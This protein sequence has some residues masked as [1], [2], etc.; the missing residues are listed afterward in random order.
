MIRGRKCPRISL[1][2][3]VCSARR[4]RSLFSC[5]S[6]RPCPSCVD[7]SSSRSS[8]MGT[9]VPLTVDEFSDHFFEAGLPVLFRLVAVLGAVDNL[10]FFA[11][12]KSRFDDF[13]PRGVLRF[14]MMLTRGR[15]CSRPLPPF[16]N[17][18]RTSLLGCGAFR[19][20]RSRHEWRSTPQPRSNVV[21]QCVDLIPAP[22][23]SISMLLFEGSSPRAP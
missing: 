15:R 2:C 1:V 7:T 13:Q 8:S 22:T 5:H 4:S 11:T 20:L 18:G 23:A 3:R 19:S 14:A 10:P 6:A 21:W 9:Q 17:G 16:D 12:D